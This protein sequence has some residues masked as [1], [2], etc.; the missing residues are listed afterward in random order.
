MAAEL[1][2]QAGLVAPDAKTAEFLRGVGTD[3]TEWEE[4]WASLRTD[5]GA[6]LQ[7]HHVFDADALAPQVAAPHSPANAM[8]AAE[9]EGTAV[10]VAYIGACTGAK[11]EDLAAAASVLKG[12]KAAKG[13]EILVAPSS[14]RDQDRAAEDGI[15]GVLEQAGARLLPNACGICAG[16]G[17]DRL[18]ADVTCISSTARNFRGRMG[19]AS[20][21]VWLGSPLTV[22]ASAVT[23]RITDPREVTA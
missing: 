8:P 23:G 17:A 7:E 20:S 12:H 15:L 9:A 10:D 5:P 14:K 19:D 16:Y 1:G 11:Y 6:E 2:G 21:M 3:V 4:E 22:A 13:V 18:G